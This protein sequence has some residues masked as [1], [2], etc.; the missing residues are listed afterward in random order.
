MIEQ[1]TPTED[2]KWAEL[3]AWP[4]HEPGNA[5][6]CLRRCE[7]HFDGTANL[8]DGAVNRG[9]ALM[10]ESWRP[11][12]LSL[13]NRAG[14]LRALISFEGK[15]NLAALTEDERAY[16]ASMLDGVAQVLRRGCFVPEATS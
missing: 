6:V 3:P 2:V 1:K 13:H 4:E 8:P 11:E 16:V 15:P 10:V 5:V 7:G 14:Y 9:F 12:D